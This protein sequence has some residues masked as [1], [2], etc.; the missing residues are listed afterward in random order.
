MQA[1]IIVIGDEILI[2]Q[3]LDTNSQMI[4]T[5][6]N[7]RGIRVHQKRVIADE[8]SRI[9]EALQQVHPDTKWIFITGGLGPTRDDITKQTLAEYFQGTLVHHPGVEKQVRQLF[10]G[11]NRRPTE[12]NLQ[13][14]YVPSTCTVL[15]NKRGTAPGMRFE[16]DGRYYF[17]TPGVPYETEYLVK[18]QIIPWLEKQPGARPLFHKTF[19]TQGYPESV[20]AHKL[21]DWENQLPTDVSLAYL[22][23]PGQVRLR[24]SS[25]AQNRDKAQALVQVQEEKLRNVLGPIIFGTDDDTLPEVVG[26]LLAE[27]SATLSTAESCTGGYLAH[28][29]TSVPGSSRY[30]QGSIISYSNEIKQR[31]LQVGPA[32]LE[33]HGAV[34]QPVVEQMARGVRQHLRTDYALA[35]SGVAGPGGGTEAK[36]VGFTW[37]ALAGPEG[38]VSAAFHFGRHRQRNI[39]RSSL[40][41]LDML[42]RHLQG[43]PMPRSSA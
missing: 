23:S 27:H 20:L 11:F 39:L 22:P 16:K 34:S 5:E 28:Q 9:L 15:P 18:E 36:P 35:S 7:K 42:R 17:S 40:M 31:L 13:Q 4:A 26:R 21:E 29:I 19:H 8:R 30:F 3:T 6:L 41:A 38:V 33:Q 37:L 2:G 14:A 32:D 24:L 43:H 25:Q 10:A 12:A 1:E